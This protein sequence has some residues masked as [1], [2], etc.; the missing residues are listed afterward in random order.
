MPGTITASCLRT[1]AAVR[2][3]STPLPSALS[4]LA[5][6]PLPRR[7][8]FLVPEQRGRL[9]AVPARD[10]LRAHA[11]GVHDGLWVVRPEVAEHGFHG[12]VVADIARAQE[13]EQADSRPACAVGGRSLTSAGGIADGQEGLL[14]RPATT[15]IDAGSRATRREAAGWP[16]VPRLSPARLPSHGQVP[17]ALSLVRPR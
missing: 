5:T 8:V 14:S 7:V 17:V 16:A 4:A 9:D 11:H 1:Q 3:A 12:R 2:K 6:T 10:L 15:I 13:A